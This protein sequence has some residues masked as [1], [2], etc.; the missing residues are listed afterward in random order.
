MKSW[1]NSEATRIVA[2]ALTAHQARFRTFV[3]K[4]TSRENADDV[5]QAA[6]LRALEGAESLQDPSRALPWLYRIHKNALVDAGRKSA[7]SSRLI[8]PGVEPSDLSTEVEEEL[9]RCGAYQARRL[10][11]EY[12]QILDL[13]DMKGHTISETADV[14]GISTNN[15]NVR[16]HRARAALRRKML[17]HCGVTQASDCNTCRCGHDGCC[18]A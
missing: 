11:R 2:E 17:E 18:D 13:V 5:M 6:A 7:S 14:L 12:A 16:L 4:R 3:V 15:A 10:R 1:S 8:E 9:C